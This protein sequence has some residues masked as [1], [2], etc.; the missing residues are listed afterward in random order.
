MDLLEQPLE[1]VAF[2]LYSL[3]EAAARW[4]RRVDLPRR[5]PRRGRRRRRRHLAPARRR[6][7]RRRHGWCF[8][9]RGWFGTGVVSCDGG[10]RAGEVVVGEAARAGLVAVAE[11]DVHGVLP[12]QLLR[13]VLP[14]GRRRRR[15]RGGAR[16]GGGGRRRAVGDDAVRVG[17]C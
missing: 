12:R 4:R 13:R 7:R 9:S 10:V 8:F 16:R 5:R 11:G 14:H 2:R 15:R 17:N 3:P 6:A 1:A